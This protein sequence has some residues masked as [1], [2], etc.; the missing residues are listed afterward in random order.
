MESENA[1]A[2]APEPAF[3]PSERNAIL[4][5]AAASLGKTYTPPAPEAPP[6]P[7]AVSP[8]EA[9]PPPP[10]EEVAADE[11]ADRLARLVREDRR[12]RSE[13]QRVEMEAANFKGER[14]VLLAAREARG[15]GDRVGVLKALF[16]D[17]DPYEGMFFDLLRGSN[18]SGSAPAPIDVGKVVEEKLAQHEAGRKQAEIEH[19]QSLLDEARSGY[20]EACSMALASGEFPLVERFGFSV[21]EMDRVVRETLGRTGEVPPPE[22]IVEYFEARFAKKLAGTK[23]DAVRN[24]P[25]PTHPGQ[26]VTSS[27]S[28]GNGEVGAPDVKLSLDQKREMLK[29]RYENA[30]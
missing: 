20:A 12:L 25:Q 4:S 21:D 16:P 17:E 27:W 6:A 10:A 19:A 14:E 23:Y 3:D 26:T 22:K 28:R 18:E 8:P 1:P 15:R 2:A 13:R 24:S 11:L 29:K 30:R 9:P 5:R 7:P